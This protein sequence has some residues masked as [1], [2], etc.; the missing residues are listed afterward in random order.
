MAKGLQPSYTQK[1][2]AQGEK[3]CYSKHHVSGNMTGLESKCRTH[4]DLMP[5]GIK[6]L[7]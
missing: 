4:I 7:K 1:L 5:R 2:I 3:T 6:T